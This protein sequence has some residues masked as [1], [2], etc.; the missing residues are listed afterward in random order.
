MVSIIGAIFY[1][2]FLSYC[3]VHKRHHLKELTI[4]FFHGAQPSGKNNKLH[5]LW[6][7]FPSF[8]HTAIIM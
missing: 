3:I 5:K 4:L 7:K 6:L 8:R 2:K 1:P